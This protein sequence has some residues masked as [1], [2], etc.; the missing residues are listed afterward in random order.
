M[1]GGADE[2]GMM[3]P[4]DTDR[5]PY[6]HSWDCVGTLKIIVHGQEH[7]PDHLGR[8]GVGGQGGVIVGA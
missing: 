6:I 2:S 3:R 1:G 4:M 7:F 8:H 5:L